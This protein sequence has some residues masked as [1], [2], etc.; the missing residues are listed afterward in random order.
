MGDKEGELLRWHDH[1]NAISEQVVIDC[2]PFFGH[3]LQSVQRLYMAFSGSVES[4]N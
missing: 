2:C 4:V 3:N 1:I